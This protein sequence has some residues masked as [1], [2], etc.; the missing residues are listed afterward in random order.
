MKIK[1]MRR[2]Y[3]EV[4]ALPRPK[5]TKP[6]RPTLLFRTLMRIA[7]APDLWATRFTYTRDKK[8]EPKGPCLIL[9]NHSSFIDLKMAVGAL[10]PK[11]FG[12]VCTTDAMVG[13][14]LL[15]KFLGCIPT[16]K[17]VTDLNLIR[18]MKYMLREKKTSVL[19]YPEAGYSFDGRATAMA[20]VMGGLI[21]MLDVPV[22]MITTHNAFARDPLYN[23]LQN[24]KVKVSADVTTLLTAEEVK[25]KSA[26]ELEAVV[27]KAFT[28]DNLAEQYERGVKIKETFRA[29]GL[30]RILYKCPACMAEGDMEGKGTHLTCHACGKTW[31]LNEDSRLEATEGV[32]EFAHIPDWYDWERAEVKKEI[33]RGEYRLDT[34]VKIGLMV[35][36]KGLYM[37]GDGWLTHSKDGFRLTGCKGKL[38]YEQKPLASHTLNA[39]FYWYCIRDV[40]GIG[41][42]DCLYYCFP[43]AEDGRIPPVAKAR[44]ATEELYKVAMAERRRPSR[45]DKPQKGE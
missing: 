15:M 6:W 23:G 14:G 33:D 26:E 27:Q 44:L 13:K 20:P 3:D 32:T 29:D 28:F 12:I 34:P 10:Y 24:R 5:H 7:S 17:F 37:V 42:R 41:D 25:T 21:K 8:S 38:N 43:T 9:M 22:L 4:M 16:Q 1:T 30:H 11:R 39:D 36:Y 18:D 40:I 45:T 2:T 35:D 31:F 19:L